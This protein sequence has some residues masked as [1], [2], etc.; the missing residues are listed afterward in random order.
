MLHDVVIVLVMIIPMLMFSVFPGIKVGNYL[1]KK[2]NL[3]EKQKRTVIVVTTLLFSLTLS[4]F[5][6]YF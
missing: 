5:L 2:Y 3:Q 4:L 6:H 1:E